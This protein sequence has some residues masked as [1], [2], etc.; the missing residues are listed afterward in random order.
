MHYEIN[1]ALNKI[2]FFGTHSRSLTTIEKA[3]KVYEELK[4]RFP[5]SEGYDITLYKYSGSSQLVETN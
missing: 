2:H 5:Q 4:A 1:I 3:T